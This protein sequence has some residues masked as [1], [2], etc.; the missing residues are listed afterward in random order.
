MDK[1]LVI[2]DQ[3]DVRLAATVALQQLGLHCLEA[4]GPEH[5]LELLK[6]EHI[7]L[8]LLDMNYKLDTTSGEEGLRFFKATKSIR[9]DHT[10]HCHDRMGQY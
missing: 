1:I 10:C 9:F 5:A 2:D 6:S 3:A 4:E 7:S 8:I